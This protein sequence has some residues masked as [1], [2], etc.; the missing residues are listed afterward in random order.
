M[1]LR[2]ILDHPNS[3]LWEPGIVLRAGAKDF[4]VQIQYT[5]SLNIT[6]PDLV[7]QHGIFNIGFFIPIHY[8]TSDPIMN[9]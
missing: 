5:A 1:N 6:N 2:T 4:L 8:S 9:Q 3:F 7:Q